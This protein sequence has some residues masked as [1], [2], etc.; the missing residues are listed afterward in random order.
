MLGIGGGVLKV[1]VLNAWCGVPMRVAAATSAL[2][3]AAT[4]VVG[5]INYYMRGES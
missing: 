2:M 4:A 5:A 3:I 1:P